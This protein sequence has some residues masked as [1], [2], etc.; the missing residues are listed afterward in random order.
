MISKY[1]YKGLTWI[2]LENPTKG[3]ISHVNEDYNIPSFFTQELL[4]N[5][6]EVGI[7]GQEDIICAVLNFPKIKNQKNNL[8]NQ[9]IVFL[10]GRDFIVTSHEHSIDTLVQFSKKLELKLSLEQP[11][12]VSNA[13]LVYFSIVK[14]LINSN[15]DNQKEIEIQIENIQRKHHKHSRKL[16]SQIMNLKKILIDLKYNTENQKNILPYFDYYAGS[17]FKI[18]TTR[19]TNEMAMEYSR[20]ESVINMQNSTLDNLSNA[21]NIFMDKKIYRLIYVFSFFAILALSTILILRITDIN[22]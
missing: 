4:N 9:K 6:P 16:V 3:E 7:T 19:H 20:L 12:P 1:T 18:D 13:S 11:L 14:T 22:F 21:I 17:F 2:D 10:V 8:L 5:D 15:L